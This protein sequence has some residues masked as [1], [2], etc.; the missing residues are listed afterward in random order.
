MGN[1]L[2]MDPTRIPQSN[3]IAQSIGQKDIMRTVSWNWSDGL[4]NVVSLILQSQ[5]WSWF[6]IRI[7][8]EWGRKSI[9]QQLD[10]NCKQEL[11]SMFHGEGNW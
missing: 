10:C 6:A 11:Q 1:G 4:W 9:A 2:T 5:C 7:R 8:A 3:H